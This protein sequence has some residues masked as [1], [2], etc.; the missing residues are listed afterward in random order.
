MFLMVAAEAVELSGQGHL[1]KEVQVAL[2]VA[3][4][5]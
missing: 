4:Q 5:E 3:E 1:L 2:E